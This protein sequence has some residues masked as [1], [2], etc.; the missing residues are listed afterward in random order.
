MLE[1]W[2]ETY[3]NDETHLCIFGD[4]NFPYLK[5]KKIGGD[6]GNSV[7]VP[8]PQP[9]ASLSVQQQGYKLLEVMGRNFLSQRVSENTRNNKNILDLIFTNSEIFGDPIVIS[10]AISDHDTI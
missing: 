10:N 4:F 8:T 3:C 1:N 5:W 2:C 6:D 7:L 9:G